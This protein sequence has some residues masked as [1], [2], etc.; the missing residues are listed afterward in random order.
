ML[1]G[2]RY[3]KDLITKILKESDMLE[4][5]VIYQDILRR[6][7]EQEAKKMVLLQLEMRFGKLSLKVRRQ[8]ERLAVA[9]AEEL[10]KALLYFQ[11]QS[12]MLAW[13]K[14]QEAK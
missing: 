14:Q 7:A 6:G 4:E 8:I 11:T 12:D 10:C 1:A 2:L 3:D 5:S 13:F 9:Q